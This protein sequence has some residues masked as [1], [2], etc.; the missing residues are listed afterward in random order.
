MVGGV[1]SNQPSKKQSTPLITLK[2]RSGSGEYQRWL[3]KQAAVEDTTAREKHHSYSYHNK[4]RES[5]WQVGNINLH[6][7]IDKCHRNPKNANKTYQTTCRSPWC[8]G[9]RNYLYMQHYEK[10]V[11][12]ITHGKHVVNEIATTTPLHLTNHEKWLEQS[13][14]TNNDLRHITGY[15]GLC[16][17]NSEQLKDLMQEEDKRWRRI[18]RRLNKLTDQVYW[19]ETA[20]ELELV[21]WDKL[22]QAEQFDFKSKQMKQLI[23][24]QIHWNKDDLY[25]RNPF[26]FVHW[27]GITNLPIEGI[28]EV[29]Q[30]EYWLNM[31]TW[32]SRWSERK[33]RDEKFLIKNR[34]RITKTE[35]I[36]GLYVQKLHK[37]KPLDKNIRKITSYP[38]KNPTRFKHSFIGSDYKNGEFLTPFELGGL[39]TIYDKFIGRQARGVFRSVSNDADVWFEVNERLLK[40]RDSG[41][42][43]KKS[44]KHLSFDVQRLLLG[45]RRKGGGNM[46]KDLTPFIYQK[47]IAKN[48]QQQNREQNR[49]WEFQPIA[50][51]KWEIEWMD[52]VELYGGSVLVGIDPSS[53]RA[54]Y[55]QAIIPGSKFNEEEW[56]ADT[57]ELRKVMRKHSP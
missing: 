57:V 44:L 55:Q 14:Y 33:G 4:I 42:L 37:N 35:P 18:K 11:K 6:N 8:L 2:R 43:R 47:H 9:C 16:F 21:R 52:K 25:L 36:S 19:I 13:Q 40:L 50:K 27:H 41:E 12:R 24:Y 7:K 51:S 46:V 32:G 3:A 53:R 38:F 54:I 22:K 49:K 15:V 48:I 56:E 34:E 5:L 31:D 39:M 17:T 28:R 45:I 26:L 23:D 1:V 20:Y 10:V 30:Q 29:F